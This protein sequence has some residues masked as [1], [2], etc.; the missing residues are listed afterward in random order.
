MRFLISAHLKAIVNLPR[1]PP[2]RTSALLQKWPPRTTPPR[3]TST[4]ETRKWTTRLDKSGFRTLDWNTL[5]GFGP[6]PPTP[7]SQR[8]SRSPL[9][10]AQSIEELKQRIAQMDE[11]AEKLRKMQS[12]VENDLYP[13]GASQESKEE[14]DSRSVFVGNVDYSSTPEELQEYFKACGMINRVTILCDKYTGHPKG[15]AYIEFAEQASVA[16]AMVL[17]DTIFKGRMIKVR[18]FDSTTWTCGVGSVRGLE[19]RSTVPDRPRREPNLF[20]TYPEPMPLLE[21]VSL[22][23]RTILDSFVRR[24]NLD[25]GAAPNFGKHV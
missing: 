8:T 16:G 1:R 22:R 18:R 23:E 6:G 24:R 5:T 19:I 9:P 10:T 4:P 25:F 2:A 12:E 20:R 15:F 21:F 3:W 14:V 13:A 7:C 11:E 17:N